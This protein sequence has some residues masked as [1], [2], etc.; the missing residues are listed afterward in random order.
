VKPRGTPHIYITEVIKVYI[1]VVML[2]NIILQ[3]KTQSKSK[4]F[5]NGVKD[6]SRN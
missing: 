6:K 3:A 4:W 2:W 5:Q 1:V